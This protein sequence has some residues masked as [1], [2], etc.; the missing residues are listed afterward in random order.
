M[1]L[2]QGQCDLW[3]ATQKKIKAKPIASAATG[4]DVHPGSSG[5][6]PRGH[7]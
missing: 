3:H 7:P 2:M 1:A 4:Y 5:R 6:L